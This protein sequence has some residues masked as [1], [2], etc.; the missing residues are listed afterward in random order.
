M[1]RAEAELLILLSGFIAVDH[2]FDTPVAAVV[3]VTVSFCT[4]C[5]VDTDV[6]LR[7]LTVVTRL[8]VPFGVP[9][10]LVVVP[11]FA[12]ADVVLRTLTVVLC[13]VVPASDQC[14]HRINQY[15]KGEGLAGLPAAFCLAVKWTTRME[16]TATLE[17]KS[18]ND[19]TNFFAGVMARDRIVIVLSNFHRLIDGV[20]SRVPILCT[21]TQ[22]SART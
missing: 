16:D 22:S 19:S 9:T 20:V 13:V 3:R 18:T 14:Q 6:V 15:C 11:G 21:V 12:V 7:P 8:V 17:A 5:S 2:V 1:S 4:V 10:A